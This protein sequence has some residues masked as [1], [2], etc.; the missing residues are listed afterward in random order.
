MKMEVGKQH[1]SE[2]SKPRNDMMGFF[3]GFPPV[4]A[5]SFKL[6]HHI[7]F[8]GGRPGMEWGWVAVERHPC[9]CTASSLVQKFLI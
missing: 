1:S 5:V 3:T 2:T 6:M 7:G 4:K 8:L 9:F